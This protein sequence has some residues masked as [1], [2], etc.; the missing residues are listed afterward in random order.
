MGLKDSIFSRLFGSKT[1][2]NKEEEQNL[3]AQ[4]A[5]GQEEGGALPVTETDP[6]Q[7]E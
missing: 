6:T 2:E 3:E 1:E 5:E 4:A 7:M